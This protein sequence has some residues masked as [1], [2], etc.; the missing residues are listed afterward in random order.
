MAFQR[1]GPTPFPKGAEGLCCLRCTY[2][3]KDPC[4]SLPFHSAPCC[5]MDSSPTALTDHPEVLQPHRALWQGWMWRFHPVAQL[6]FNALEHRSS[7]QGEVMAQ[8]QCLWAEMGPGLKRKKPCSPHLHRFVLPSLVTAMS[9]PLTRNTAAH[10][11]NGKGNNPPRP[12]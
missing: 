1:L 7:L 10:A 5:G 9:S 3:H 8:Q 2:R 4:T 6:C 11:D 12:H